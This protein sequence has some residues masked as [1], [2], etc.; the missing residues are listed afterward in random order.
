M[1]PDRCPACQSLV[2][3]ERIGAHERCTN[4]GYISS[5]CDPDGIGIS[6]KSYPHCDQWRLSLEE[7]RRMKRLDQFA[8]EHPSEGNEK[9][10]DYR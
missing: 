6:E 3:W 7:A 4:C 9:K 5:C 10:G 1:E 2:H 8:K